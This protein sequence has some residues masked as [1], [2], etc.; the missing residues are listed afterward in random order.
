MESLP[1]DHAQRPTVELQNNYLF[2]RG[3]FPVYDRDQKAIISAE[4]DVF[5]T[6]DHLI[7]IHDKNIMMIERYFSS[8]SAND[9]VEIE[10][11]ESAA[12]LFYELLDYLYHD[13]FPKLD[14]ISKDIR[15]IETRIF[16]TVD[17]NIV[18]EIM[19]VK[20]NIL[21]FKRIMNS[22]RSMIRQL[23]NLESK[24][25]GK[26]KEMQSVYG[27]LLEHVK[28]IWSL[29]ETYGESIESL[30][31]TNNAI[32]D[33]R[34]NKIVKT[35]TLITAIVMPINV[36][37]ALFGMNASHI[38]FL[39]SPYDFWKVMLIMLGGSFIVYKLFKKKKWL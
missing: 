4:V 15:T 18:R 27:E 17:D 2:I 36:L 32:V 1:S 10:L 21:T 26:S 33:Q 9:T 29:L 16:D 14:N 38:P 19:S 25:F 12:Y 8:L 3:L 24:L 31:N 7:T 6:K 35:L 23:T 34:I 11:A 37:G 22:H 5:I 39:G 30:E 28:D 20:R 13:L